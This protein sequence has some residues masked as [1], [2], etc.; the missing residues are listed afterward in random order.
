MRDIDPDS[1][2]MQEAA[3]QNE[4]EAFALRM[5]HEPPE[6]FGEMTAS[7]EDEIL[8]RGDAMGIGQMM[9]GDSRG[10]TAEQWRSIIEEEEPE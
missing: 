5:M 10:F 2:E 3:R 8:R 7:E 4:R 1:T 9:G 6:G